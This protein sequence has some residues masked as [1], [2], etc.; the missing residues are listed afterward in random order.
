MNAKDIGQW[1]KERITSDILENLY[2][3]SYWNAHMI[4]RTLKTVVKVNILQVLVNF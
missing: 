3:K 4:L 1:E 2:F